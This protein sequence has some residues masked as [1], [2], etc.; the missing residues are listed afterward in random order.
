MTW[1]ILIEALS[2]VLGTVLGAVTPALRETIEKFLKDLYVKAKETKNP[3][4]D[5]LVE[6]LAGVLGIKLE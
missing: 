5:F 3:W 6:L 1:R 2:G 4:D